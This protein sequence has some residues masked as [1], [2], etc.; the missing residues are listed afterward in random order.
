M[1]VSVI[2][3]NREKDL[4]IQGAT[5]ANLTVGDIHIVD[6]S[7]NT[8]VILERK[9]A[10]DLAASI[11]DGRWDE[12]KARLREVP[13]EIRKI[14]LIEGLMWLKGIKL[15]GIPV[16]TLKSACIKLEIRDRIG[17]IHSKGMEDTVKIIEKIKGIF[18]D[19]K[20]MKK[21]AGL[22]PYHQVGPKKKDK[23]LG[24]PGAILRQMLMAIPGIS[25]ETADLLA[26][27]FGSLQSLLVCLSE[28]DRSRIM[29]IKGI[30]KGRYEL[31]KKCLVG[32]KKTD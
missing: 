15:E 24:D 7:G 3:D 18:E 23:L 30:G 28:E 25:L 5:K 19:K 11:K 4:E 9:T 26:K 1:S 12:Q 31:L 27:E 2:V 16:S 6:S 14:Y 29:G 10:K 22:V 20:D 17:V 21:M 32:E 8:L 13:E